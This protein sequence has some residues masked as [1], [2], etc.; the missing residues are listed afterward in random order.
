MGKTAFLFPGQGSQHPG[1]AKAF[2]DESADAKA[3]IDEADRILDYPL[4]G[5]MFSG[6]ED[7]LKKT[8]H[9]QPALLTAEMVSLKALKQKG[10]TADY[11]AG[12]SLGEY[13]A[14][15]AAGVMSYENALR[16]V[17]QR[18]LFMEEAVP[19]GEGSMSA[20]MGL[21]RETVERICSDISS[22]GGIVQ[23][24]NLNAPGQIVISGDK[25]AI[26]KAEEMAQQE[27]AKRVISLEVSG[28]FHSR[29]M[30]PAQEKLESAME[31]ISFSKPAFPVLSNVNALE[32]TDPG[33]LKRNVIEQVT[34]PVYWED[35]IRRLLEL[36][37]DTFI[38]AGPGNVLGGL[39]RRVQRRGVNVYSAQDPESVEKTAAALT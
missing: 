21:E 37:V 23:A 17:K 1:M 26:A 13:T 29:M 15:T 19:A 20:L 5:M 25:D 4:S 7:E 30:E 11:A 28:P 2:Y 3:L 39:V 6:P 38:E 31:P 35:T 27:K 22:A 14:L 8:E 9:A 32:E 24:A 18:G 16:I 12:H 33:Q 34:S 36:G 10:I